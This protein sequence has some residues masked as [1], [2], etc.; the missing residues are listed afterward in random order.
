LHVDKKT[1]LLKGVISFKFAIIS[2]IFSLLNANFSLTS[3]EVD[4]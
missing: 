3:K 4:L 1:P 2:S